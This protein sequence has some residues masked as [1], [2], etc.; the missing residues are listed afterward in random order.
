[1]PKVNKAFKYSWKNYGY[2]NAH[3]FGS[4]ECLQNDVIGR[5]SV[6]TRPK[7]PSRKKGNK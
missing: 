2:C 6:V 1:M 7:A 5:G 4:C 3:K